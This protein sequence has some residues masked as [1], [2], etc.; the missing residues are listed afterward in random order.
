MIGIIASFIYIL[1]LLASRLFLYSKAKN[2]SLKFTFPII[3]FNIALNFIYVYFLKCF[4][5]NFYYLFKL[6]FYL[7][8]I[9]Q[10][11]FYY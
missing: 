8:L 5:F 7:Q 11:N 10:Y 6:L 3:F 1:D 2:Y 9:N 4:F